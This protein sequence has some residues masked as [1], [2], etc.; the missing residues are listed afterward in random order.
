MAFAP[1]RSNEDPRLWFTAAVWVR[2]SAL[3]QVKVFKKGRLTNCQQLL[4]ARRFKF[5]HMIR[6]GFDRM[7][8]GAIERVELLQAVQVTHKAGLLGRRDTPVHVLY[9]F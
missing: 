5:M 1:G 8:R 2:Y 4:I 7:F 6:R 3:I 9:Y